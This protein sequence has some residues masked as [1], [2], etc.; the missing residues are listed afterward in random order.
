[1]EQGIVR[2]GRHTTAGAGRRQKQTADSAA[3][4]G[5]HASAVLSAGAAEQPQAAD[6]AGQEGCQQVSDMRVRARAE[7]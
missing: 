1:M 2:T 6:I 5:S 3:G 7:G 4:A